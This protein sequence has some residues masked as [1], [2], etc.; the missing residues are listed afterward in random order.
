MQ[1]Y[2]W[3][4]KPYRTLSMQIVFGP[5]LHQRPWTVSS[6]RDPSFFINQLRSPCL[7][8]SGTLPVWHLSSHQQKICPFCR[9][10][11]WQ[12]GG[13]SIAWAGGDF[14]TSSPSSP[15][16]R[17]VRGDGMSGPVRYCRTDNTIQ[18]HRL[19]LPQ[20]NLNHLPISTSCR[21]PFNPL[22]GPPDIDHPDSYSWSTLSRHILIPK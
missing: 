6:M 16:F 19:G 4:V 9:R 12:F 20:P 15:F 14:S 11:F 22:Q 13:W 3:Q 21:V 17:E 1:F 2:K 8:S 18:Q 7:E 5:V 10:M